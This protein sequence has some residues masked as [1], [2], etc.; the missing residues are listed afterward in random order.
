MF[1]IHILQSVLWRSWHVHKGGL[2]CR[3][4]L[5]P[6]QWTGP[7]SHPVNTQT[8]THYDAFGNHWKL[9]RIF[10]S[11]Q[12]LTLCSPDLLMSGE[13]KYVHPLLLRDKIR[14][15]QHHS[16]KPSTHRRCNDSHTLSVR[17]ASQS[18]CASSSLTMSAWPCSL[19]H[20]SA[21]EPSSSWRLT[22]APCARRARTMS[23]LPWLTA[24]IRAVWP[25]WAAD[26]GEGVRGGGEIGLM[27][28]NT[29]K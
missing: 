21:V 13:K 23:I 11:M 20:I 17:V 2:R 4:V 1:E 10:S 19:A 26:G 6:E 25:A 24:S 12:L 28:S 15:F 16:L 27:T 14:A 29:G 8:R 7:C 18:G 5:P 3:Y 9:L 22:S